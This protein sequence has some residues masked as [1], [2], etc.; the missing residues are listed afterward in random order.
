MKNAFFALNLEWA[1][2]TEL[3]TK[4]PPSTY[5]QKGY[6]LF[7]LCYFEILF[8]SINPPYTINT[9]PKFCCFIQFYQLSLFFHSIDRIINLAEDVQHYFK[10][11]NQPSS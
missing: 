3:Q 1:E 6:T 7:L 2:K 8:F 9:N 5:V 4:I 11:V 10:A